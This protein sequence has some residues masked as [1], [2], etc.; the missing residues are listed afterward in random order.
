MRLEDHM[1]FTKST[2]AGGA[3]CGLDLGWV[4]SIIIDDSDSCRF[5]LQLKAS[6]DSLEI[7]QGRADRF[8]LYIES[9]SDHDRRRCIQDVVQP[10]DTQC[11]AS[12]VAF[13]IA[14]LKTAEGS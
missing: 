9:N 13:S 8:N 6:I 10:R 3:Q 11:E 5:A 7:L 1:N 4:M 14:H 2:L 12:Q